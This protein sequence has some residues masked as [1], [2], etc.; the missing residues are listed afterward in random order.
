M[1]FFF[2]TADFSEPIEI[3][4]GV[5]CRVLSRGSLMFSLVEVEEGA[6]SP[7]HSHPEEQMGMILEG[8]FERHQGG[9]VRILHAGEGFYVPPNVEHGGGAVDGPCKL[10][11]AFTPPRAAYLGS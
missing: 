9:E 3:S 4:P 5:R 8:A 6:F 7:L 11:D 2:T 10:L 1:T